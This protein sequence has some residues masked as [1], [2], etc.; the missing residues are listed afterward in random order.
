MPTHQ[1]NASAARMTNEHM[2]MYS[3]ELQSMMQDLLRTLANIDL[4]YNSE[5]ERLDRSATDDELKQYIKDKIR[6]RHRER[7]EPYVNLLSEI[8]RQQHNLAFTA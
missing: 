2:G 3:N 6:A 8:R 7:R 1:K 4:E 5:L